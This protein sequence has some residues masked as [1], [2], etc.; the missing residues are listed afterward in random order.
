MTAVSALAVQ[1]TCANGNPDI[2]IALSDGT[3]GGD[4][5]APA[6]LAS[7]STL[8]TDPVGAGEYTLDTAATITG[9]SYVYVA[10]P[11][12]FDQ[13]AIHWNR[14][15]VKVFENS[16]TALAAL[17]SGQLDQLS[18]ADP[19]AMQT[20]QAEGYH[21]QA[22]PSVFE[23]V[24]LWDRSTAGG[25][26]LGNLKVRQALEYAVD[27]PAIVKALYGQ[28]GT[29]TD[30]AGVPSQP[31]A[32]NAGVN[33]Y[34][35]YDPAKAKT[36]LAAAGYPDGFTID[37]EDQGALDAP[38]MQAVVGYWNKIGVKASITQDATIPGW[39]H[40]IMTRKYVAGAYGYGGLPLFMESVNWFLPYPNPFNPFGTSDPVMT[41]LL[42]KAGTETGATQ[43]ADYQAVQA[44][45]VQQA[46]YVGIAVLSVAVIN[47]PG[48]T[49]PS[50]R[51]L[52]F[53]N[54]LDVAKAA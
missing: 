3:T 49:S 16:D 17:R 37:V 23:G 7:P 50:A 2:A 32:W 24:G 47:G 34:Y 29:V 39:I 1:I 21:L 15:V 13:G 22:V 51:G 30:Q 46:W 20:A 40:N 52:Y 9:S 25:N 48:I 26:P 54:E 27:R 19:N 12:Y 45:G 28:F 44:E 5:V 14:I 35:G 36:L 42:A 41:G 38:L 4:I 33:T 43:T 53:G 11:R 31:T 8:A 18:L 10:N 6:S